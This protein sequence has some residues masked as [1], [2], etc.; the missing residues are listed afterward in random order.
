MSIFIDVLPITKKEIE[1]SLYYYQKYQKDSIGPR[2]I[3]HVATMLNHD[4][5]MIISVDRHFDLIKEV[6]RIDPLELI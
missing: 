6:N 5:E 2:D 3:I 4:I 1:L